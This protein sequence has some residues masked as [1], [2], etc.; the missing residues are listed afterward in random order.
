MT[1]RTSTH[2]SDEFLGSVLHETTNWTVNGPNGK[3]LCEV[4]SLHCAVEQAVEFGALGHRVVALVRERD[5]EIVLFSGQ[6]RTLIDRLFDP[7]DYLIALYAM[8]G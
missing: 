5:P 3:V 4:A 6:I 1:D 7:D 8:K 2:R